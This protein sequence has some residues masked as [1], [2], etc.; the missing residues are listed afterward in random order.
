LQFIPLEEDVLSLE[1][2][3]A[4][5][6]IWAVSY[7]LSTFDYTLNKDLKLQ[8]GDETA[9]YNS[10]QALLTLQRLY[11]LFPRILGKGDR[12]EVDFFIYKHFILL[13]I[14]NKH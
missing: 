14:C 4:F 6:E 2:E 13:A 11:G 12:A 8:D 10:A 1:H 9:L 7:L 3:N 5:K